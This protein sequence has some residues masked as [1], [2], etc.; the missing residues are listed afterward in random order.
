[1][2]GTTPGTGSAKKARINS[3]SL[4][5]TQATLE[6]TE[7]RADRMT[8]DVRMGRHSTAG[9]IVVP[10]TY[11][12]TDDFLQ[13][14]MGGAWTT[15]ALG[16]ALTLVPGS[17]Q[18]YFSIEAGYTDIGQYEVFKGSL[19]NSLDISIKPT[20][21]ITFTW[22]IIGRDMSI[23]TTSINAVT[24]FGSP[25]T[26]GVM[27]S[28]DGVIKEGG[29]TIGYM[30]SLDLK[31]DN[32][33][34][35][36]DVIGSK[37]APGWFWGRQKLTGTAVFLFEDESI[38]SKFIGET[39]SSIEFT[40]AGSPTDTNTLDFSMPRVKYLT[41][42]TPIQNEQGIS[43]SMTFEGLL[44]SSGVSLTVSKSNAHA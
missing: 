15:G 19:I 18:R 39:E 28:F 5:L 44:P 10:P 4:A 29:T 16:T 7:I 33:I 22:G 38:I 31:I 27:S 24:P 14:L 8:T 40:I 36:P 23:S 25:T 12:D 1:V 6:S 2:W 11:G 9:N 35:L 30:T 17:T 20:A 37:L 13:A 41:A 26:N 42:S 32:G 43:M 3:H 21:M 34:T